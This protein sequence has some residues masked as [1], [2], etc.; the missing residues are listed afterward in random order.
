MIYDTIYKHKGRKKI[1][2]ERQYQRADARILAAVLI[3]VIGVVLNVL[4]LVFSQGGTISL[5][6]TLGIGILSVIA[7]IV[8]YCLF[9]GKR[10]CGILMTAFATLTYLVM[11][12]CVDMLFFYIL[13]AAIIV[14]QMSYL[15]LSRVLITGIVSLPVM[16]VKSF[17]LGKAGIVTST[18][19]GTTI[20]VMFFVYGI[21]LI[22]T[23]IW[24]IFNKENIAAV[25]EGADRQKATAE[26]IVHVSEELVV[27]FDQ[28]DTYVKELSQAIDTG[29]L[30]M[31]NIASSIENTAQA[32]QEQSRMCQDIEENTRSAK[33]Q[34]EYM[35]EA[36]G[37][38][39]RNV[40]QGAKAME[41]LHNHA[42]NVE[43][44]NK[45]TVAYVDALNA[46]TRQVVD[47]LGT[48]VSI[49]SQTN[50]LALNA[51]IEAA[52]AGEAGR[53]F[54][55]V[56][57]E[58]RVLSEQT[59]SAT[60]NIST[61]LSELNQDVES[62]TTSISRS[63]N[64][65]DQ[66][67]Q[68]IEET[69]TQ[70]DEIDSGVKEL[71]DVIRQVKNSIEEIAEAT[72]VIAEGVTGLSANSQEVAA[73]SAEGTQLMTKAVDNMDV[74]NTTLSNIYNLAQELKS[75]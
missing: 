64:A 43:K 25:K 4:G 40:S 23:K 39:L 12:V 66:Q 18:E 10:I 32:I 1:M 9:K 31:Q 36:S 58:I 37:K 8:V 27:N 33:E 61:I 35:V 55:V 17:M 6:V 11:V 44:E 26:R 59:K 7:S 19:V 45:E 49:S 68:L 65:V 15:E 56:A 60:E 70:F 14:A 63:V 13:I 50:L 67:N 28:A 2:T 54:A 34:T 74:V 71:I 29:N 51:S 57:D 46:R 5:Y 41:E 75:E 3:I 42:Q 24:V 62:V 53:G 30:S 38:A 48:I 22:V 69:K 21:T 73:V 52:R 16:I 47:I 72:A 20:V